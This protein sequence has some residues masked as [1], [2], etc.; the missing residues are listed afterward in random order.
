MDER[1]ESLASTIKTKRKNVKMTQRELAERADL[2]IATIRALEQGLRTGSV[3][4][5][6]AVAHALDVTIA[7]LL[8]KAKALPGDSPDSGIVAI[9]RVLTS[10]DDLLDDVVETD[11]PV[12]LRAT[13]RDSTYAWGAYWGG[14]Y[15]ELTA[16]LA[17]AMIRARA[18][19]HASP[20]KDREAVADKLAQLYQVAS[21]TLVHLG[22]PDTAWLAWDRAKQAAKRGSDPLRVSALQ[23]SA[24]WLLLTEGRYE[25]SVQVA[26]RAAEKI[27]V[28]GKAS[29]PQLSVYGNLM[30]SA[31]TATGRNV[32]LRTR[33]AKADDYLK[34]ARA[35][36][37]R[38]GERNDY[39]SAFGRQQV[40][41]QTTDVQVVTE[42]YTKALRTA[43]GM[44]R[45]AGLPLA[46]R[47]RHLTDVAYSLARLGKDDHA[48][49]TVLSI[50]ASAPDWIEHQTFYKHV[51]GE[52]DARL[53]RTPLHELAQKIGA[54]SE[55]S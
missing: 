37:E 16:L 17:Q 49:N 27:E 13:S 23:G 24:S 40:I 3:G 43:R 29:L 28:D 10:V 46:A 55:G 44:P 39:E 20:T 32:K 51:V 33:A 48:S 15:E 25:D 11:E 7:D 1:A 31:A 21:C 42:Q 30:L 22:H 9:R 50:A 6:Q 53:M 5:L 36:A 26:T 19:E 2:S 45:E 52:L 18:A 14:R 38:T 4:T 35:V 34:E 47:S 54:N 41:M 12:S 8:A